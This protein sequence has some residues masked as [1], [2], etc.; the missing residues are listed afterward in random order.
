MDLG[1]RAQ[2]G[3]LMNLDKA[4]T[5]KDLQTSDYYKDYYKDFTGGFCKRM[6]FTGD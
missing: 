4:G 6:E 1:S 5:T 3:F 2:R